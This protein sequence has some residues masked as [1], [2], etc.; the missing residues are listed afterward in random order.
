LHYYFQ[1]HNIAFDSLIAKIHNKNIFK[2]IHSRTMIAA[3]HVT[4]DRGPCPDAQ[5]AGLFDRF[6]NKLSIAPTASISIIAGYTSASVEPVLSNAFTAKTLSGSYPVRNKYLSRLIV[7]KGLDEEDMWIRI[8]NNGGSIQGMEEFTEEEQNVF[9]TAYEIDQ[10]YIIDLAADRTQYICQAQSINLF[11]PAD[12]HKKDI[13]Q[14]HYQAWKKGLKSLYYLR[15]TSI[16]RPGNT[17][18]YV[19]SLKVVKEDKKYEECLAC[20]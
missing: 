8:V 10:R 15:S 17:D 1:K 3:A 6:I 13:H 4:Q 7:K 19:N 2:N 9:K 11:F 16:Q 5:E 14:V 20:Q 18:K 12:A